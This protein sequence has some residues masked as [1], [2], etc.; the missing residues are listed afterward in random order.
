MTVSRGKKHKYLGMDLDYSEPGLC[1]VSMIDYIQE[2]LDLFE[3]VA[4]GAKGTK[5]SAAPSDLFVVEEGDK[6]LDPKRAEQFHSITAKMLFATK[7]AR[8]DTGTAVAYLTTRVRNP[9]EGDWKKL[10]HLM[11][12]VR[13][14]KTLPLILGGNSA[15]ILK[16]Y[17]DGSYGV[18]P[19]MRGQSGG[20]LTM[21]R[22]FP[23]GSS[24]KQKINGRSST[25][26]EL[27]GVDDFMPAILWTRRFLEAQDYD[28][29]EN[30]VYQDNK[31][32]MLLEKNG[33]ASSGK[34]TKHINI[35]FFFI[36]DMIEKGEVKVEWC[37]TEDM[38][39]DFWTKPLQGAL[40]KKFRDLI[41]GVLPQPD[42]RK[43]KPGKSKKSK[44]SKESKGKSE[45][46]SKVLARFRK[47]GPQECVGGTTSTSKGAL[48][49]RH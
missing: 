41:M 8:Q 5:S 27:I 26:G 36:T 45:K 47:S 17:I 35:R 40:F 37:P 3:K 2:V 39:A 28:V 9:T 16:W 6:E 15:G 31:S 49:T 24:T 21:G 42:P 13:G 44:K 12:Y 46:A 34:R 22:G 10:C 18:H 11:R 14:T 7:R 43:E 48:K 25:E 19:N 38:T 29:T 4:P 20:G 1:K 23:N 32:A 33:K 30:I